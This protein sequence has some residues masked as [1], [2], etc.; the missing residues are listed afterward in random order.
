MQTEPLI[1][2]CKGFNV[3]PFELC[4]RLSDETGYRIATVDTIIWRAANLGFV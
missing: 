2:I 3:T 1:R 4:R